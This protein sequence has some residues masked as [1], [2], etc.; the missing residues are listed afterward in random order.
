MRSWKS[1]S[2]SNDD[3]GVANAACWLVDWLVSLVVLV[4]WLVSLVVLV[5]WLVS[6]VVLVGWLVCS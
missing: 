6:L 3:E 2:S 4:G 1:K 5:G